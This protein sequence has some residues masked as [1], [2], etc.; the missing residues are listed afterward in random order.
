MSNIRKIQR[1]NHVLPRFE[2]DNRNHTRLKWFY[3]GWLH[4]IP[5]AALVA[6]FTLPAMLPIE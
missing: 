6:R 5:M 4:T 3:I 1:R 2:Y